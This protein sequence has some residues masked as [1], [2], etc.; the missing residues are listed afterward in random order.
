[1]NQIKLNII[2]SIILQFITMI[3]GFVIPRIVIFTFG[4][5]VNGLV[6]SLNQ[7]LNY[8]TLI[9]GGLGGVVIASLYKPLSNKNIDE[10][11]SIVKSSSSFFKK[12]ALVILS[13]SVALA[14]IYPIIVKSSFSYEYTFFLCIILMVNLF[15]QYYCS[16]TW[17]MLLYADGKVYVINTIQ[18]VV[19][20]LNL[21][22]AFVI[23][24]IYPQIHLFK[25]LGIFAFLIQPIVYSLYVKKHYPYI[26]K[27]SNLNTN[28]ENKRWDG[29]GQTISY[30]IH[31]NTD[32]VIIT[33]F[34]TLKD[35]SVY[36]INMMIVGSVF[37][38]V[39]SITNS[40]VPSLGKKIA[41]DNVVEAN[42]A[43][44]LYEFGVLFFSIPLFAACAV[45][46]IPF[47]RIYTSGISDTNYLVLSFSLLMVI[48]KLL[49]SI[50]NVYIQVAYSSG[51]FK[52]TSVF[53]YFEAIINIFFSL[54][55]VIKIGINGVA[56][57]TILAIIFRIAAHIYY[58]KKNIVFRSIFYE[59]K[60]LLVYLLCFA[61]LVF[62]GFEF[63]DTRCLNY[64]EWFKLSLM[65]VLFSFIT[66]FGVSYVFY[67]KYLMTILS[68]LYIT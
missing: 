36:S 37:G 7:F 50:R 52:E 39:S 15:I 54:L 28:I 21:L 32:I 42:E 13:Y 26:N 47:L 17:R 25:I 18:S 1:M 35:V 41:S 67:K 2:S 27:N 29:F 51:K 55:L 11:S 64:F 4:S 14:F 53:A 60:F 48:A 57:G 31:N 33:F 46:I 68:K 22:F 66:I 49:H 16:L 44:G 9:E 56:I 59:I 38:L 20:I 63:T 6:S 30:F 40:V 65:Y 45:L 12:V 19:M 8:A 43:F 34:L 62:V 61:F 58:N 3:Y 24:N 10:I 23:I 5:E